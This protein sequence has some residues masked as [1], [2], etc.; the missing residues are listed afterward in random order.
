PARDERSKSVH[1][2]QIELR[3]KGL[4][5]IVLVRIDHLLH[6]H[7]DVADKTQAG[8]SN[9]FYAA[10]EA[11]VGHEVLHDLDGVWV[12]HLY[13]ANFV[14]GNCVPK[15]NQPHLATRVVVEQRGLGRLPT[16]NQGGIGRKLT[17]EV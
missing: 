11:S 10:R 6:R 12:A 4:K 15:T 3:W 8:I 2:R 9:D 1:H 13:P 14:K 7:I 16:R 17:E 5:Q